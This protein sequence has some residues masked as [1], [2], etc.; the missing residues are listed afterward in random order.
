M[1]HLIYYQHEMR[2][3]RLQTIDLGRADNFLGSMVTKDDL[4]ENER[5]PIIDPPKAP[6]VNGSALPFRTDAKPRFSDPPAP[7][8]QQPLPEKPDV[9]RSAHAYEP[10]SPS[11]KRSNTER[12]RSV[13]NTSPIRQ[14][15]SSQI[16][17]LAEDLA[18]ARKELDAQS[19]RMRD[20]EE[21]LKKERQARELAEDVAKRLELQ[22]EAKTNGHAKGNEG[23]IMEDAFEP[24]ADVTETKE[25]EPTPTIDPNAISDSSLLLEKR[26]ETMLVDMQELR[27]QMEAFKNRAE[28]A[29]SERDADRKT[30]A[31]MV[32]KIRANEARRSSSTERAQSPDAPSH[33]LANGTIESKLS[34]VLQKAGLVNGHALDAKDPNR[35]AVSTLSRPPGAGAHDSMLYHATPYASMIGVVII[36]MGL[37]AYLNG[38]QP[39][40]VDR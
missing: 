32:E 33:D 39:P 2:M 18:N 17:K 23:S 6:Q 19:A 37:M 26:L 25:V 24:P 14:E 12:P 16:I 1:H 13:P 30:L 34:P 31:E 36:G 11:L 28:I 10:P 22:S 35:S 40:K 3:A 4:K 21:M 15:P 7:P 27:E 20:L 29:E 9:A 38:W 5:V 8:P